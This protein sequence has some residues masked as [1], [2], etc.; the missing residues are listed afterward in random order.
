LL[1]VFEPGLFDIIFMDI[2]MPVMDGITATQKIKEKY[3]NAI[4]I[5]G[6]SANAFEGDK[7]KYMEMGMDEYLMK[8]V[9]KE[10]FF[11]ILDQFFE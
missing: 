6:L 7:E 3:K 11:R 4:P 5:I 9:K 1:E 10:D 2:Q 8:P